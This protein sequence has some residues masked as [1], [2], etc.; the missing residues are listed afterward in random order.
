MVLATT[1]EKANPADTRIKIASRRGFLKSHL[2]FE[3]TDAA[4]RPVQRFVSHTMRLRVGPFFEV[5]QVIVNCVP[6]GFG[7]HKLMILRNNS[8][9]IVQD[10]EADICK[11][12]KRRVFGEKRCSALLAELFSKA[13]RNLEGRDLIRALRNTQVRCIHLNISGKC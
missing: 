2:A 13:V 9:N 5:R 7:S 4:R 1:S 11:L 12:R 6:P 3:F 10:P 8:T